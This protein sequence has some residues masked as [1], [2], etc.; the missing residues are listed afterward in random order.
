MRKRNIPIM[1]ISNFRRLEATYCNNILSNFSPVCAG[2]PQGSILGPLL[3]V[4]L[5]SDLPMSIFET[6]KYADDTM[7]NCYPKLGIS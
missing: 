7:I 2:I 1:I 3:F 4:L 5:M 6:L